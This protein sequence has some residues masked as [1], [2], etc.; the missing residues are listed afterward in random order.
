MLQINPNEVIRISKLINVSLDNIDEKIRF[1][2]SKYTDNPNKLQELNIDE[3][4][5]L[6]TRIKNS[7]LF[8]KDITSEIEEATGESLDKILEANYSLNF[9]EDKF[10]NHYASKIKNKANNSELDKIELCYSKDDKVNHYTYKQKFLEKAK[11]RFNNFNPS[12]FGLTEEELMD[13]LAEIYDKRGAKEANAIIEALEN[14]CP[15]NYHTYHFN[16]EKQMNSDKYYD[17]NKDVIDKYQ[18]NSELIN[19]NGYKFEIAQVLP[20]DCNKIEALAYNFGKANVINTM[21]TLP[22]KYLELCS[23]GKN[24]T[25]TLTCGNDMMNNTGNWSGYYKPSTMFGSNCSNVT[26]DIHGSFTN[27]SFYTQ[28]TLIHEM[29]HKFDDMIT[30]KSIIDWILG[31]TFYTNQNDEWSTYYNKYNNVLTSINEGG[32]TSYPNVNE[33]FADSTVAY[34]KNPEVYKEL[35]PESYELLSNMLDGEYGYSY[36]DKIVAI[37]SSTS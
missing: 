20:K 14:N 8:L 25:I 23:K 33:F 11:N 9:F 34:F 21:R 6:I 12:K 17:F 1:F 36:D 27:N 26:V 2:K 24:N 18:T 10:I 28:D 19:V 30:S 37:L 3:I 4:T 29:G 15:E 22:D 16:P 31:K 13:N 32:Y 7:T 35:C 5:K